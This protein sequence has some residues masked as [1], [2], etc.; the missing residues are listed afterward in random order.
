M[1]P[2]KPLELTTSTSLQTG[3]T[4]DQVKQAPKNSIETNPQKTIGQLAF[5]EFFSFFNIVNYI[6][7]AIVI[8]TGSYR[9]LLFMI[10]VLSNTVIGLYQKIHSRRILN[11]LAL[12]HAQKY[13]VLRDGTWVDVDSDEIAQ[14]DIVRLSAGAQVPCDGVIRQG[15]CQVNES[16]LTGESDALDRIEG[17]SLYGGCF[18]VSGTCL[19]QAVEVG[20]AQ[21]MATI[22]KEAKREKEYPSQLRD[23]LN[24]IIKFC[25]IILF[26]AGILLFIKLYFFSHI[27]LNTALLNTTASMVGMIPEGLIIL[28]STALAAAAVK[29]A[30]KAVL[31]HELYCIENL[32]RVDTLCLDKTGTITS[33]KMKVVHYIPLAKQ[34]EA[35]MKQDLANL[36]GSLDDD[37]MTAQAI[38]QSL[39]PL[40]PTQKADVRFPFSSTWKSSGAEFGDKTLILGAYSFVFEKTDPEVLTQI[41]QYAAKGLRVLTLAQ[42]GRIEK[43]GRGEYKLLGLILIE[44]E[45]R[46]DAGEILDYF[47][48]QQVDLK[49]ISGD[50][51]TTVEAIANKA[52]VAGKAVDMSKVEEDQ[53]PE[54]VKRYSIFGRVSPTQKMLMVKA[55]QNQGHTVGMTGDGVNDVMALKQADCSIAMG[56]GAQA[57]MAVA[58]L[59]L[60]Q[61]QFAVLPQIVAEGRCVIN[62]IQRT[63][64]LFLVKTIFSFLLTV[65]TVVWMQAYPFVPI[66]LTFVSAIGTGIPAFILTFENDISRPGRSFL[67]S[68]LSRAIPGAL[69]ISTGI[70]ILYCIVQYGPLDASIEQYQTMC[71]LLAVL[72]AIGVLYM[73][74]RPLSFLRLIVLILSVAMAA[75]GL[76]FCSNIFFLYR[77]NLTYDL[78]VLGVGALQGALLWRLWSV[79]WSRWLKKLPLVRKTMEATAHEPA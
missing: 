4:E 18:I 61:D 67:V 39:Y 78:V 10:I 12:L 26:P 57:A 75:G 79:H 2:M 15:E 7:A 40:R 9:N 13:Q 20:S 46:P 32:A 62:N 14:G 38:R 73:I 24:S 3:L 48:S 8:Y 53:I 72:N 11:K 6:L 27:Q 49:I 36:F 31:I 58:S 29:M 74:C 47:K 33:G 16:P 5:E 70:S 64:S 37:N 65:L 30:R 63:A 54:V 45:I 69:A 34:S 1:I 23:V 77:L 52:G 21:Y 76:L 35:D 56:S 19:M 68:V 50:M 59:V 60:L 41:N 44:D 28:T 71:T 42:A 66:Q 25:T 17:G 22:L 55:L 51:V 43:L